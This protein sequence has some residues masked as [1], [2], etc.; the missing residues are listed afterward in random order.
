[1]DPINKEI[2]QIF[3]IVNQ[4]KGQLTTTLFPSAPPTFNPIYT[5]LNNI[6]T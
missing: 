6:H 4:I 1:M 2:K 5:T 3:I